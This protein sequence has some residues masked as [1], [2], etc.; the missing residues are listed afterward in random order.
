MEVVSR[1]ST[2]NCPMVVACK[3]VWDMEDAVDP[4]PVALGRRLLMLP[5]LVSP[6]LTMTPE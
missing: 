5:E 6:T 3:V 1:L 2:S 4:P